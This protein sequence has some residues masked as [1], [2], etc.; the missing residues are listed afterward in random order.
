VKWEADALQAKHNGKKPLVRASRGGNHQAIETLF[1]RY[2]RQLLGNCPTHFG[3]PEDAEDA[4][5]DALL[6]AVPQCVAF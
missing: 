6:S 5:Q 3:K 4:L 1:R 2:Q